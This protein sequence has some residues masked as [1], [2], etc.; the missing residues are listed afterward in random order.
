MVNQDGIRT[1]IRQFGPDNQPEAIWETL[2]DPQTI[3][4][5]AND[6]IAY[7]F[8]WLDTHKGPLVLE[9]RPMLLGA[10]DDFR[11][12]WV[13]SVGITGADKGQGGKYRVL[14]HPLFAETASR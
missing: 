10:I 14:L 7:S 12:R 2:V 1:S 6:N 9:I 3:E 5:T 11:F 13:A 8:N 4:L